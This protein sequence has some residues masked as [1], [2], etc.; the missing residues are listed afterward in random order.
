MKQVSTKQAAKNRELARIKK[1]LIELNGDRCMICRMNNCTD[2]MHLLPR[3]LF[4]EYQT[5]EWNLIVGCRSCHDIFDSS[6][7]FRRKT[8]LYKHVAK[9]DQQGAYRYFQMGNVE[10]DI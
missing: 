4:P 9:Y 8:G 2:L 5:S 10:N 3:S 6:A 1:E 7:A